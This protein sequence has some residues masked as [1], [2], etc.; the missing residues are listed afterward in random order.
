MTK[1]PMF[2]IK[3]LAEHLA[4]NVDL[5]YREVSRGNIAYTR[6]GRRHIRFSEAQVEDYLRRCAQRDAF[7]KKLDLTKEQ[8]QATQPDPAT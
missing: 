2:T 4:V 1:P 6:V 8:G 3:S 7:M 5:I